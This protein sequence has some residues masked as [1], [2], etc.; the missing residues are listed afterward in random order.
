MRATRIDIPT[1]VLDFFWR[2]SMKIRVAGIVCLLILAGAWVYLHAQNN[3]Q[4]ALPTGVNGRYQVVPVEFDDGFAGK[5]DR[6]M[7]I[8]ID[9]QT[10]Q[11]WTLYEYADVT[12]G[13]QVGAHR[14]SWG[15]V[16]ELP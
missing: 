3:A 5:P 15:K 1:D 13:G 4:A 6:K 10:G 9:T 8:R 7:V 14:I 11:T 12:S 16:G 2:E